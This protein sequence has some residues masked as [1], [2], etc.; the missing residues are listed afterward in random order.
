MTKDNSVHLPEVLFEF[1]PSG[2]SVR[3]SALDPITGIEVSII[4]DTRAGKETMKRIAIRKLIRAILRQREKD[5]LKM[6]EP[7][8]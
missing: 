7:R 5:Q 4:G 3:V 2:R 1:R 6:K 8:P